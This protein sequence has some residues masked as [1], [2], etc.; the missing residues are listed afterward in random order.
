MTWYKK[1]LE[2]HRRETIAG[3]IFAITSTLALL[4]WHFA[5]GQTFTYESI[6]PI[7]TIYEYAF[8]SALVFVG[9]GAYLRYNTTLYLD[10]K[11]F[12]K[13]MLKMPG[14]HKGVKKV[15][16]IS[17][18]VVV[19]AIVAAVVWLLN[20]IISLIYNALVFLLYLYPPVGVGVVAGL[21]TYLFLKKDELG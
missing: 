13:D 1:S 15:I 11:R 20:T 6:Q 18:V 17:M 21:I 10:L 4:L 5:F 19:F 16:W 9:P 2:K 8:Y 3:T 7:S 14:L 12:F